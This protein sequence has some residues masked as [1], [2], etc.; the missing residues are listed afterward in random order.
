MSAASSGRPQLEDS[1]VRAKE[2]RDAKVAADEAKENSDPGPG[3]AHDFHCTHDPCVCVSGDEYPSGGTIFKCGDCGVERCDAE[4]GNGLQHLD[5]CPNCGSESVPVA[6]GTWSAREH[7]SGLRDAIRQP[8]DD[9]GW[10]DAVDNIL[11]SVIAWLSVV[12]G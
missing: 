3:V 5:S 11:D 4:E 12:S 1:L 6:A 2:A 7:P 9:Y 10:E 8:I